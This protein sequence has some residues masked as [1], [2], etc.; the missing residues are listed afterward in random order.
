MTD[1]ANILLLVSDPLDAGISISLRLKAEAL[2]IR[3][4]EFLHV[5]SKFGLVI[6]FVG[7]K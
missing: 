5:E 2:I 6:S 1:S 3:L 7:G 4:S